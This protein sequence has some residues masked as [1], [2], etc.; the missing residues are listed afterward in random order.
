M[1]QYEV[2]QEIWANAYETRKRI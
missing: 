2:I 1:A